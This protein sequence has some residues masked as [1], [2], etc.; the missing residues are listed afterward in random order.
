MLDVHC[1]RVRHTFFLDWYVIQFRI[2]DH[3]NETNYGQNNKGLR[4]AK[5]GSIIVQQDC[6]S[7]TI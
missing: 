6:S 3:E 5:K 1:L 2:I 4:M 7:L